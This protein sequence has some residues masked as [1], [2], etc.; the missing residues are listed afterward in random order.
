MALL[1]LVQARGVGALEIH[2]KN[3]YFGAIA[4]LFLCCIA[5]PLSLLYRYRYPGKQW[6]LA[7]EWIAETSHSHAGG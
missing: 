1:P 3:S 4:A 2:E 7:D 5:A 6:E